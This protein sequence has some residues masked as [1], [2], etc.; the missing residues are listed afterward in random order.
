MLH[1]AAWWGP[2]FSPSYI[3]P[4]CKLIITFDTMSAR[5]STKCRHRKK[6]SD[7]ITCFRCN[8]PVYSHKDVI[9][10]AI[11]SSQFVIIEAETGSGKSTQ[12]PQYILENGYK[13]II[14]T[15]PRRIAAISLATRVAQEVDCELGTTVGYK[16][17]FDSAASDETILTYVSDGILLRELTTNQKAKGYSV[18]IIDEAH[19]RSAATDILMAL[20]KNLCLT[21][22]PDLKIVVTSA[23]IDVDKFSKYFNGATVVRVAGKLYP[24]DV[25]YSPF[26]NIIST[27]FKIHTS[28]DPGD[29]LIF[30]PGV[31]EINETCKSLS[32]TLPGDE[33]LVLPLYSNLPPDEQSKIFQPTPSGCRKI[34]CATNVAET[35]LTIEGVVYVIDSGRVRRIDYDTKLR[36]DVLVD[37]QISR[38]EADQRKGRAGRLQPGVCYRLYSSDDYLKMDSSPSAEIAHSNCTSYLLYLKKRGIISA[39]DLD[40]IDTPS[41]E[42]LAACERNL[43]DLEAVDTN[44]LLTDKGHLIASLPVDPCLANAIFNAVTS[45]CLEQVLII[46]SMLSPVH[47]LTR[48]TI[49]PQFVHESG[50]HMTLYNI[51]CHWVESEKSINEWCKENNFESSAMHQAAQIHEQL[52]FLLIAKGFD[53]HSSDKSDNSNILQSFINTSGS[54][55]ASKYLFSNNEGRNHTK[56]STNDSAEAVYLHSS[57]PLASNPPEDILFHKALRTN[58][59]FMQHCSRISKSHTNGIALRKLTTL[60]SNNLNV[61]SNCQLKPSWMASK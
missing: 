48:G 39:T 61:N 25:I 51:Y 15:Q 46:V 2:I 56:Y 1:G 11:K 6:I 60:L 47:R 38:Q 57:H 3:H 42:L 52:I 58:L 27:V 21:S 26:S 7:C 36:F 54:N 44:G 41:P 33:T 40:L 24:V 29:I 5:S 31:R 49:D 19:Q 43:L 34:I 53:V 10:S 50:D 9:L 17:R 13:G 30:L 35:S 4:V 22:R 23:T 8:L 32:S 14:C 59:T 28:S 18:V 37:K 16:V 55:V 12:I 20:L 45:N